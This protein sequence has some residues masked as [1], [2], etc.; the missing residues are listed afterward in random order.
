VIFISSIAGHQGFPQSAAYCATK[1]AIELLV[2]S[3][4]TEFAPRGVRVNAIAPGYFRTGMTEV[5]YRDPAWSEAMLAKIPQGRFGRLGDVVG[6][7]VF[8]ASDASAYVTGQ[9]IPVDGGYLASI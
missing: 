1:G 9:C 6:A 4:A 7:V 3:L 5:F 2:R 8:L